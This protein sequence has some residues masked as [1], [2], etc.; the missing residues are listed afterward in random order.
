MTTCRICGEDKET[1]NIDLYV[2]GSEGLT[3]CHDCEMMIVVYVR[4]LLYV[5]AIARKAGY[6]ACKTVR[7]AK[8]K[9]AIAKAEAE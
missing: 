1:R 6:V 9:A 2:T 8:L 3:V 7:D 5:S 4:Q